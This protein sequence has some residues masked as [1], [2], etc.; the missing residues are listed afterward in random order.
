VT[1][2]CIADG[3]LDRVD[4]RLVRLPL[5]AA[6]GGS[7]A[8]QLD[9][10][11]VTV[12]DSDG[13]TGTGFT[14]ALGPGGAALQAMVCAIREI[15]LGADIGR[16]ARAWRQVWSMTHRLGRGVAI[17]ALSAIDIAVWDLRARR[18]KVP[19]HR[20]LGTFHDAVPIYGSGRATHSMSVD[21]LVEGAQ[22]YL[23]EGFGAIKLR[24]GALGLDEDL[25]RIRAVRDA[26][27]AGVR[28]MVDCNERL[29][30]AEALW[31]GTRLAE[32]NIFW[33]EEPLVSDDV[34]GHARLAA[35]LDVPIAVGEHLIGRYE[36]ADYLRHGAAA[37]L[38]PDAPLMG[39]ISEWQHVG[40]LADTANATISPHFLP[41]LH[42]HLAAANPAATY[43]EH[44]PLLDDLLL[45]TLQ[46]TNGELVPPDR[47]GHGMAWDDE[48]LDKHTV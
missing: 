28:I 19:L 45:D 2:A 17:P 3:R 6:R 9:V 1:A 31:L 36:F 23:G 15:V 34:T 24:A 46:P 47:P 30:F 12:A 38:Q 11:H 10:V 43:V 33:L 26:V 5:G 44:F 35:H 41:E 20:L 27:G 48:A 18:A 25:R 4:A 39:G 7:G 14:Y 37:T 42:V 22:S 21:E 13:A 29:T 40:V 8:T 16:W 32:L